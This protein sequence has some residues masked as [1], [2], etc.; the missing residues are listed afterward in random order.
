MESIK[1]SAENLEILPAKINELDK[2]IDS[3]YEKIEN[4][5]NI[6]NQKS[7]KIPK[8]EKSVIELSQYM[9]DGITQF[10]NIA[11]EYISKI[12]ELEKLEKL[13]TNHKKELENT[14]QESEKKGYEK[15][16]IDLIKKIAENHPTIFKEIKNSFEDLITEKYKKEDVLDINDKNKN[17]ILSFVEFDGEIVNGKYKV[18]SS[19]I[20]LKNDI[21]FKAQIELLNDEKEKSEEELKNTSDIDNSKKVEE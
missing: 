6:N 12:S 13:K 3:L 8:K 18:V 9:K 20:L 11:K 15:G 1:E 5:P 16:Q 17:D 19:A 10:E 2:K 14:K 7:T 21:L 4:L